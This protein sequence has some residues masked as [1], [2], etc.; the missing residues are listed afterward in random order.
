VDGNPVIEGETRVAI[1]KV[2]G[3]R[4]LLQLCGERRKRVRKALQESEHLFWRKQVFH[5]H[6]AHEMQA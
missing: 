1:G 2:C 4:V 3:Y 6:E 5:H